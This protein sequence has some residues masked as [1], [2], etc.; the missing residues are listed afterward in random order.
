MPSRDDERHAKADRAGDDERQIETAGRDEVTGDNRSQ[1]L[2]G[3][4][5]GRVQLSQVP[6]LAGGAMSERLAEATG[7]KIAV[8]LPCTNR[9]AMSSVSVETAR[10]VNGRLANTS[11]PARSRRRR[12]STSDNAPAGSLTKM[13]VNVDAPITKPT[14]DGPA[15][16]SRANKGRSGVR[17]IA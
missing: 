14:S 12:P 4:L 10:Y 11:A 3:A 2:A 7:P 15:P 9:S 1:R 8:A 16:R 5:G 13:P 17:Q 6:R